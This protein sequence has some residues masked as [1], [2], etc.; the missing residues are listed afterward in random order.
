MDDNV[1][2]LI[3]LLT[4]ARQAFSE[5]AKEAASLQD[6]VSKLDPSR[7]K[8]SEVRRVFALIEY[9]LRLQEVANRSVLESL[10]SFLSSTSKEEETTDGHP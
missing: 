8:T 9:V 4:S 6:T 3:P 5:A 2:D 7:M 10:D 1:K